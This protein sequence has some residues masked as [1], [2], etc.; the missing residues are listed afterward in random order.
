[1]RI[2]ALLHEVCR[3]TGFSAAFTSARTGEPC[4]S[5]NAL[6]AAILADAANLGPTRM[7]AAGPGVT[8][9]QLIWIDDADIRPESLLVDV[10]LMLWGPV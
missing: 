6:L 10:T 1:M 7:A 3:R 4:D 5:E 9:D 8:R 2:T